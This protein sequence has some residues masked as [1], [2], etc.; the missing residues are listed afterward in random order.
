[1]QISAMGI[2]VL[3]IIISIGAKTLMTVQDTQTD[4]IW[5]AVVNESVTLLN[6]TNVSLAQTGVDSANFTLTNMSMTLGSGN[7]TLHATDGKVFLLANAT[8][9][10]NNTAWNASYGY[11]YH[12]DLTA[13]YNATNNGLDA[14]GTYSDFFVVIVVVMILGIIVSMFGSLGRRD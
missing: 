7:Y 6:G 2:I 4:Y 8:G 13:D 1:M 11:N 5:D 14:V 10:I 12:I 3:V 9:I